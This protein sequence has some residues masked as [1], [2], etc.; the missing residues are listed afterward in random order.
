M[1]YRP[2][3]TIFAPRLAIGQAIVAVLTRLAADYVRQQNQSWEYYLGYG[4]SGAALAAGIQGASVTIIVLAEAVDSTVKIFLEESPGAAQVEVFLDGVSQAVIDLSA[5]EA[6]RELLIPIADDG[7]QHNISLVN[8]GTAVGVSNATDWLS[9]LGVETQSTRIIT[10]QVANM[11]NY[12]ISFQIQD[13]KAT[14]S[15]RVRN[16]QG[17]SFFL[18]T[19]SWTIAEVLAYH[20][21]LAALVD[22]CTDGVIVDSSVTLNPVL[23]AGLKSSAVAGSDVQEG[24]LLGFS[25]AGSNYKESI[26]IPAMKSSLFVG[27]SVNIAATEITDL[28]DTLNGTTQTSSQNMAASDRYSNLIT[29]VVSGAKSFR[30]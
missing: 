18:P 1:L 22:N 21:A 9:I 13:A 17:V 19:A 5:I 20:D 11:S 25:V 2:D 26:R 29:D 10:Q 27:P 6:A 24:G 23:P 8:L 14:G 28:R 12:I 15:A 3:P 16:K 7:M 4:L 30:K